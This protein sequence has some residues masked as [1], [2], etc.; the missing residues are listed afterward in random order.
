MYFGT[1]DAVPAD[2]TSRV[3]ARRA[4]VKATDGGLRD[5]PINRRGRLITDS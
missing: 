2:L 5:V 3:A 4:R 1:G